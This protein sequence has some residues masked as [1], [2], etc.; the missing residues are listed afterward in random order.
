MK[1]TALKAIVA[2]CLC[3]LVAGDE[4]EKKLSELDHCR[5]LAAKYGAELE[6]RQFDGSRVDLLTDQHAIE[7]DW[8]RKWA[9]G[10]GQASLY[11]ELTGKQPALLLLVDPES[12]SDQ[13]YIWRARVAC[14]RNR[15][16][17]FV[18]S[19]K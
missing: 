16:R 12:E 11:A 10:V 7:V 15:I 3:L 9:E 19:I 2:S 4:P 14:A 18:E 6:V 5:R 17:V 13:R 1:T 8:A